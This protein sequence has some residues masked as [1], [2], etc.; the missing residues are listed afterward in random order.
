MNTSDEVYVGMTPESVLQALPVSALRHRE[1]LT[2]AALH[3][4]N[5]EGALNYL[6]ILL[7]ED[8]FAA[9]LGQ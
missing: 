5:Y 1:D 6:L 4:P 9:S 3:T 8:N 2:V 7:D